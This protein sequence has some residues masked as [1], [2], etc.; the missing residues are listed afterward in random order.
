MSDLKLEDI[1]KAAELLCSYEP[2]PPYSFVVYR[3]LQVFNFVTSP[4]K[5]RN[6]Y[7]IWLYK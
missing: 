6:A 3:L 7:R 5:Y 2:P 1:K 4:Y